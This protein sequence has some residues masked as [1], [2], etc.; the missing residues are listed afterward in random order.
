[1]SGLQGRKG[2]SAPEP[3]G[4]AY[5]AREER[6]GASRWDSSAPAAKLVPMEG[7]C[8]SKSQGTGIVGEEEKTHRDEVT[9]QIRHAGPDSVGHLPLCLRQ[10]DGGRDGGIL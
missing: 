1:M 6:P 3:S 4:Q 7:P 8:R 10:V 9:G 2:L 5:V